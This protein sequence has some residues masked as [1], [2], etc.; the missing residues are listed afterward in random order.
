MS[1]ADAAT[2][3]PNEL[4]NA[5]T[6]ATGATGATGDIDLDMLMDVPVTMTVEVGRK[7]LT[8]KELLSLTPGSVVSFDRSVTEPM[9][10]MINGTL[11]AR[12]E[13][14][15]ADGKFGLRLVDVVSPKE[16]LEQLG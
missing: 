14:V 5:P 7:S 8:I 4:T 9:D 1:E 16:R 3:V 11:V 2:A 13:V 6:G 15:S 10:I 12:G